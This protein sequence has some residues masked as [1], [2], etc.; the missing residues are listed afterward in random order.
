MIS[1]CLAAYNG[2]L[3]IRRQLESILCQLGEGDEII[4]A[5]DSHNCETKKV[6]MALNDPRIRIVD[7][8]HRGSPTWNFEKT[9]Q[10]TKGD[11]IFLSDQDDEWLPDKVK[12]CMSYLK[13]YDCIVSD[14]IVVDSEGYVIC[15]SFYGLNGMH[16][17]KWYNLLVR[18][19]YIGCCMAFRRTLL[20]TIL[21]FPKNIPMHDIWI[22]NVAAFNYKLCFIPEKTIRFYRHKKTS[23]TTG[24]K[25]SLSYVEQAKIRMQTSLNLLIRSI[26]K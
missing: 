19:N 4:V 7:G 1:V 24:Y 10:C 26:L 11:F 22:G 9:L 21:P 8:A 13:K 2:E 20:D 16:P 5:D 12:I 15:D 25:S 18:N 6:I 14:N 23:S 17:G 3:Y